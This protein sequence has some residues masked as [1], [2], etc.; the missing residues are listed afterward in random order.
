MP[1][2]SSAWSH[3]GGSA[4][5]LNPTS[6][7][8]CLQADSRVTSVQR[9]L[10]HMRLVDAS[11]A[12]PP[13]AAAGSAAVRPASVT[14]DEHAPPLPLS[15][16]PP[17]PPDTPAGASLTQLSHV[18]TISALR[19]Q[20]SQCGTAYCYCNGAGVVHHTTVSARGISNYSPTQAPGAERRHQHCCRLCPQCCCR[21][22]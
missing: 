7:C 13:E 14:A 16:P 11:G 10:Q 4:E 19:V 2:G 1:G 21:W 5:A 17:V 3:E 18:P 12:A 20:V 9:H 8:A 6:L 22:S 15:P